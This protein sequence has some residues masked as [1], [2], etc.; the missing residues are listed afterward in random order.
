MIG[1]TIS[2]YRIVEKLG[3]GGM[4]VV[5]KA[6]DT[7]LDRFVALK[8]LPPDVAQDR[9]A[10]ERFRREAKAASALNHPN[11]CTIYDVGEDDGH[12]FIA[13]EL[14]EGQTLQRRIAA[15]PVPLEE[16]LDLGIQIADA[17]DSAHA[18]GIVHRDIKPG[19][20]FLTERGQVKIL[21]FGLAKKTRPKIAEV[22][23]ATISL[24]E[25]HLTT[26]GAALGTIA[27]MSPE[28]ARG[29]ELDV[30]TDLFSF[31]AVLYEMSTGRPPFSGGTSALIFHAIL[32]LAP[33]SPI[34]VNPGLP[35]ELDRIT[36]KALEKDRDLRYQIASEM[37]S[38]L[39]RLK[40]SMESRGNASALPF[41][42]Q[43]GSTGETVG[44]QSAAAPVRLAPR[45]LPI[46]LGGIIT[47]LLVAGA[48]LWFTK[49]P[50]PGLPDIV[51]RQLTTNSSEKAVSG[52]AISRDGKYLAYTDPNG[53]HVKLLETG[54]TQTTPQPEAF[55]GKSVTWDVVPT[56]VNDT[57][58]IATAF[59]PGDRPSI[60]TVSAMAVAP[61]KL[62]DDAYAWSV[63]WN[64][65]MIAFT[66]NPGRFGNREIWL[67]SSDGEQARK[68][69][70]ADSN[71]GVF[72]V[73]WSPDDQRVAYG[74]FDGQVQTIGIESRDLKGG[75]AVTML[76]EPRLRDFLWLP[77]GRMIYS[78]AELPP[79]ESSCNFWEG[80]I[81][82]HT[83][84]PLAKAR[85]L[86]AWAGFC[87]NW[88]SATT[89]AKR[90]TFQ[91]WYF[92]DGVELAEVDNGGTH[93]S[94]V[95]RLT[96]SEDHAYP[97]GWTADSRAVVFGSFRNG[98]V[99]VF[100]QSLDADTA[101]PVETGPGDANDPQ[102]SSDGSWVLYH[103][104]PKD[105]RTQ[106]MRVPM[107]GGPPQL[108]FVA[109][110]RLNWLCC[111]RSPAT[112]CAVAERAPD[113]KQL[114]FT[115]FDPLQGR[116]RLL[117][118]FDVDPSAQY[119]WNLSADGS[120]I[121]IVKQPD[122]RIHIVPLDGSARREIRVRSW[123]GLTSAVWASDG[124]GLFVGADVSGGRALLY[125][126]LNGNPSLL[127]QQ[128]ERGS[129]VPVWGV[130]S[131]D[132]RHLAIHES[133]Q[134]G[135]MWMV[136]NF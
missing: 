134:N 128:K 98:Q 22:G 125:V 108:V 96:V 127:W 116:G 102:V 42:G 2:H 43:P 5:Y 48:L 12:A 10:L 11:I 135:N 132:G 107:A 90:L 66:T 53:I 16:V 74:K 78:L 115:A 37:R 49:R 92:Q 46:A 120:R 105:G 40:R 30:R 52:G 61:R 110:D 75:P 101:D 28:Q 126:D 77:D 25:E 14:L 123:T 94:N 31:G 38:D 21:D 23:A 73:E 111:A 129:P 131:P 109:P 70:E 17:L 106:V 7:R 64:G 51:Q 113:G 24:S 6:E 83:S 130:P 99:R 54:E 35:S 55:R 114:V 68:L 95:H 13:M 80:P 58:F 56:W 39:K 45:H 82:V 33:I 65:S 57:R 104:A 84:K 41:V 119:A 76:S 89:D 19:N 18:K 50:A 36:N 29:E 4:G 59:V 47:L 121:S 1:Q 26:P 71:T 85:R 86:T 81:D 27:Y 72:R 32:A 91:R 124:K 63:S 97:V 100:K 133:T 136:E 62:R 3:G 34:S 93:L 103:T 118:N 15:K 67:M 9:Q 87:M 60:W 122:D 8:F 20:I 112:I 79:N 69:D 44:R 117:T 88:M